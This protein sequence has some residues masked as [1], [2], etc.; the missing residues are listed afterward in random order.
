[1][2]GLHRKS[3]ELSGLKTQDYL[4]AGT[5]L[6]WTI[7]VHTFLRGTSPFTGKAY[8]RANNC[9]RSVCQQLLFL[10]RPAKRP[11]LT[12]SAINNPIVTE[13][14]WGSNGFNLRSYVNMLGT[15]VWDFV[16]N[17]SA[18]LPVCLIMENTWTSLI[19]VGIQW[20]LKLADP[21]A[22]LC[23]L[24]WSAKCVV[25]VF[26]VFFCDIFTADVCHCGKWHGLPPSQISYTT[27]KY[28]ITAF[29][30][31]FA[32]VLHKGVIVWK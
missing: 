8:G 22:W 19:T 20:D 6:D 26:W 4:P 14:G 9:Q 17:F 27:P 29:P 28:H 32:K 5:S 25:V 23:S 30:D 13:S 15:D 3:K 16:P 24:G 7:A 18:C 2:T 1:M 11:N 31:A 10:H 21:K 12:H